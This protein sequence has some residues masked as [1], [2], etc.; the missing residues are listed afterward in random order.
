MPAEL[1]LQRACRLL[2]VRR[3]EMTGGEHYPRLSKGREHQDNGTTPPVTQIRRGLRTSF[4]EMPSFYGRHF[5]ILTGNLARRAGPLG[6]CTRPSVTWNFFVSYLYDFYSYGHLLERYAKDP[7]C[8]STAYPSPSQTWSVFKPRHVHT[9]TV[10]SWPKG[11]EDVEDDEQASSGH[12]GRLTAPFG[13]AA[14]CC[15]RHRTGGIFM[16]AGV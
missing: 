1:H 2:V 10:T 6:R 8:I 3:R 4:S 15:G 5:R 7:E 14:P 9:S 12:F 11:A 16:T 13:T